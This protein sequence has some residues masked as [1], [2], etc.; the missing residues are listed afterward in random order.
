MEHIEKAHKILT[1]NGFAVKDDLISYYE[2]ISFERGINIRNLLSDI[3]FINND[4]DE[5]TYQLIADGVNFILVEVA[6]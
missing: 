4:G 1:E 5:C 2:N 3:T 6:L